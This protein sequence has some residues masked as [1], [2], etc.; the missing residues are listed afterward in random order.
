MSDKTLRDT[1]NAYKDGMPLRL[2][3][4]MQ[5]IKLYVTRMQKQKTVYS[6]T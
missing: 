4:G 6:T 1:V 2:E 3:P 5:F